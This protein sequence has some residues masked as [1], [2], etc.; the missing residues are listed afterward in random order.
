MEQADLL[1]DVLTL[2]RQEGALDGE[3][4]EAFVA[5]LR[6]RAALILEE[7]LAALKTENTWRREAMTGLEQRTQSLEKE[8]AWRTD[9]MVTLEQQSR[10]LEQ[11]NTWRRDAMVTLEQQSRSLE[12]E[13]TWRREAMAGLETRVQGLETESANATRAHE[14]LLAHHRQVLVATVGRLTSVAGLPFF[15]VARMRRE[16]R[17]LADLLRHETS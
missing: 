8:N 5:A 16:L 1:A 17:A 12:Q 3:R 2:A 13:N 14:L 7:R 11:E 10:S 9:A 15:K 6:E 4:L